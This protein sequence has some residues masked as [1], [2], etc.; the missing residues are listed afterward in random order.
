MIR[1]HLVLFAVSFT[2]AAFGAACSSSTSLPSNSGSD[3]EKS[4]DE[5]TND[6]EDSDGG[7][8]GSD[9][10]SATTSA[11]ACFA[12]CTPD[13]SAMQAAGQAYDTCICTKSCATECGSD[14]CSATEEDV[15]LSDACVACLDGAKGQACDEEAEALCAQSDACKAATACLEASCG[16][17]T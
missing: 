1:T 2:F 5:E 12:C 3:N 13:P 16:G 6:P 11:E 4:P 8:Q 17:K 9:E 10:C 14:Y 15:Q 7:A